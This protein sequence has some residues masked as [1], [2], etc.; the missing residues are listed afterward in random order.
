MSPGAR[1]TFGLLLRPALRTTRWLPFGVIVALGAWVVRSGARD[2][3]DPA[4][5]A[6]P[7]ATTMLG[8]WLCALFE[9]PA[10]EITGPS[11]I[12]LWLRRS[13]RAS[14]AVPSVAMAWLAFTWLGPLNGPTVPMV[15]MAVAVVVTALA[16]GAVAA[17]VAPPTRLGLAAA[18]GLVG[19]VLVWPGVLAK[20]LERPLSIDPAHVPVGD[21]ITYWTTTSIVAGAVLWLAHRDAAVPGLRVSIRGSARRARSLT[22]VRDFH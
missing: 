22:P 10:S 1:S 8:V 11:P 16:C 21:P 6:L 3:G 12:P 19:S 17:R 9:D 14:I 18:A 4:T 15:V 7:I 5:V 20:I 13:V 2:Q